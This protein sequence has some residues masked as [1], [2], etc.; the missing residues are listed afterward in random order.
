VDEDGDTTY[1]V[2]SDGD[3]YGNASSSVQACSAP[4]G[5]VSDN[6]DCDDGDINVNPGKI[7]IEGNGLDDDCNPSTPDTPLDI[8]DLD[9]NNVVI[10]P[11]PFNHTILIHLPLYFDNDEFEI[12]LFD[13]NGRIIFK[14][15][16]ISVNGMITMNDLDHFDEGVYFIKINHVID[17]KSVLKRLIKF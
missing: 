12:Y 13:I 7:E 9:L 8:D 3:G 17:G 5:Y 2:D 16:S 1:Y 6:S 15:K 14:R 4:S 10:K 11:N